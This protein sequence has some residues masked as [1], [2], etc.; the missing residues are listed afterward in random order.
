MF[1]EFSN[2]IKE[3]SML[4]EKA[5]GLVAGYLS[6]EEL[7]K[8]S[9]ALKV[10][11]STVEACKTA[12]TIFRSG[13][14]IYDDYTFTELKVVDPVHCN[15]L[16]TDNDDSDYVALYI[17]KNALYVVDVLDTDRSTYEKFI[18]ATKRFTPSTMTL[19]K[20]IYAF[21]DELLAKDVSFIERLS[22]EVTEMEESILQGKPE[23]DINLTLL[24]L[25]RK[26]LEIRNYYEQCLDIFEVL[27]ADENELFLETD[28]LMYIAN[29]RQRI[30]RLREDVDSINNTV[31]HVQDAYSAHMDAKMN[32]TMK[33]LTVLTTIFFPL[34]I[35]VGWYGM[36]FESMPEFKWNFGYLYVIILSIAVIVM[37]AIVARK[38][39]WF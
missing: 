11:D 34:T 3:S 19:E 32:N 26:L 17:M 1:F 24:R 27:E 6:I 10:T 28:S 30:T 18:R 36:N 25:K 8:I 7:T 5:K 2:T 13:V 16:E 21:F 33:Y 12:N 39:K 38:N 14:E 4:P 20:L 9:S 29:M 35:I 23:D 31:V 37:F 22:L 15:G